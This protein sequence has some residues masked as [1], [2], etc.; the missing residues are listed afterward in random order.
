MR[1]GRKNNKVKNIE[2]CGCVC[3]LSCLS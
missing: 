1:Y 2:R 3:K